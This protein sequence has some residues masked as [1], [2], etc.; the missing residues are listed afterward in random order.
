MSATPEFLNDQSLPA[1]EQ[2]VRRMKQLMLHVR[3]KGEIPILEIRSDALPLLH[4]AMERMNLYPLLLPLQSG[5]D[6]LF[7]PSRRGQHHLHL[8]RPLD[9]EEFQLIKKHP[10]IGCQLLEHTA[11]VSK[12]SALIALQDHERVDGAGYPLRSQP[13]TR[14]EYGV[15]YRLKSRSRRPAPGRWISRSLRQSSSY[16]YASAPPSKNSNSKSPIRIVLP[17]LA[18]RLRSSA[19]TP[20][21]RRILA[22]RITA[23]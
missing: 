14:S 20:M 18:P 17:P 23:S 13:R 9:A 8:V 10:M 1:I 19:S 3:L 2:V 21:L 6:Y 4:E 7:P 12:R 22:N 15:D 16:R 5:S 11:S